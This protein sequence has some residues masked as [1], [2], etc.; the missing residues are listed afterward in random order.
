MPNAT[1]KFTTAQ[2]NE[3]LIELGYLEDKDGYTSL[4][5]AGKAAGGRFKKGKHGIFFL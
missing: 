5:K 1:H 4:T 2:A 3:R